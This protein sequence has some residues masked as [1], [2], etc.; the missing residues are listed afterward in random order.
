MVTNRLGEGHAVV[1]AMNAG[2]LGYD[3]VRAGQPR[4]RLRP[5]RRARDVAKTG[6]RK[7][8]AVQ[9]SRRAR[10]KPRISAAVGQRQ[11]RR[12]AVEALDDADGR[13]RARRRGRR[14][15]RG[16]V[17]HHHQAQPDGAARGFAERVGVAGGGRGA[18][19]RRRG[20]GRGGA[21][22]RQLSAPVGGADGRGR[23]ASTAGCESDSELFRLARSLAA[24]AK[25][26]QGGKVDA[27]FGGHTHKALTR[28]V[29]DGLPV[30]QRDELA[31][32]ELAEIDVESGEGEKPPGGCFQRTAQHADPRRGA[33]P[34]PAG[35]RRRGRPA[36]QLRR[37]HGARGAPA[38]L[39][40]RRVAVGQPQARVR[41]RVADGQPAGRPAARDGARRPGP[42]QRRRA[43]RRSAGGAAQLRRAVR[44]AAVRQQAR[45]R[46]DRWC[47]N[48]PHADYQC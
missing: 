3:A 12:R 14:H 15:Q 7:I 17:S 28:L 37:G 41:R 32:W 19:R 44:G 24:R 13:R 38:G 18:A 42:D 25:S 23:R 35:G 16:S 39:A 33:L 27:L 46:R 10:T 5:R 21:R 30:A 36:R 48:S 47:G 11:R 45:H 22:G 6:R 40:R 29:I 26:G 4:V 2:Q 1:R 9:R 31:G 43:A 8:R 34:G 20:G